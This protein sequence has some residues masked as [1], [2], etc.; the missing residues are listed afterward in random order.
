MS[1]T[2]TRKQSKFK[3]KTKRKTNR[4]TKRKTKRKTNRKTKRTHS[5]RK[6]SKKQSKKQ[7]GGV[8]LGAGSFGGVFDSFELEGHDTK[9]FVT[10]I[11]YG[12]K[13]FDDFNDEY[14]IFKVLKEIK[15]K[16][17]T[18][19]ILPEMI[20]PNVKDEDKGKQLTYAIK[21]STIEDIKTQPNKKNMHII[22][23]SQIPGDQSSAKY[24]DTLIDPGSAL[25]KDL[26]EPFENISITDGTYPILHMTTVGNMSYEEYIKDHVYKFPTDNYFQNVLRLS[27]QIL[28]ISQLMFK[29]G[30]LHNDI[31]ADN[32]RIS[33]SKVSPPTATLSLIDVGGI[34]EYNV[35]LINADQY[36]S[37]YMLTLTS[38]EPYTISTPMDMF[39]PMLCDNIMDIMMLGNMTN[40]CP[41]ISVILCIYLCYY[42]RTKRTNVN[43]A[44]IYSK[45]IYEFRVRYNLNE[46]PETYPVFD[47]PRS[48]ETEKFVEELINI[49]MNFL[50]KKSKNSNMTEQNCA[51]Y[52]YY[53][54]LDKA[55]HANHI[56]LFY[57]L[58]N[59]F[60][61]DFLIILRIISLNLSTFE[62][63][64]IIIGILENYF[65]RG[66]GVGGIFTKDL[67]GMS[68][69]LFSTGDIP[70]EFEPIYI[71]KMLKT[72][73]L[74]SVYLDTNI[75]TESVSKKTFKMLPKM[76]G[77][78][79]TT[80]QKGNLK[81]MI[82][83][84]VFDEL[85]IMQLISKHEFN[86]QVKADQVRGTTFDV[87]DNPLFTKL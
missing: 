64:P 1:I 31:K 9:S 63:H 46:L 81:T 68:A 87:K 49:V 52:K 13:R 40:L 61:F 65:L 30:L 86:K 38:G 78:K 22:K 29:H 66:N 56:K 67:Y 51:I 15:K 44:R 12:D 53:Q 85:I 82:M 17:D 6:Q 3:R 20:E 45:L 50:L 77:K 69:D 10:K 74:D 36:E 26:N 80:S 76:F 19:N 27:T 35:K 14:S 55:K 83:D 8:V 71:E 59:K 39:N 37:K 62:T 24:S 57:K 33:L 5:A 16:D 23:K 54:L 42:H 11:F 58:T 32:C 41:E 34:K 48:N 25:Y 84:E 4:K 21:V 72:N 73:L 75:E 2:C 79:V 60:K 28:W 70:M 43:N 47:D 7:S 18:F